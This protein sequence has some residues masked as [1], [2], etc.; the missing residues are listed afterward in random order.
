MRNTVGAEH[1]SS[2]LAIDFNIAKIEKL[3]GLCCDLQ[4]SQHRAVV[5][6]WLTGLHIVHI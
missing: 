1:V 2:M 3:D 6:V 4:P 5:C